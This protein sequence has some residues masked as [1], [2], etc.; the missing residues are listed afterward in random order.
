MRELARAAGYSLMLFAPALLMASVVLQMPWLTVA[1]LICGLP[2]LRPLFGDACAEVPEW[3]EKTATLLDR[4]PIVGAGAVFVAIA[5]FVARLPIL[6]HSA[7]D[8][9]WWGASLWAS[10]VFASC[11][12]HELVHR[13]DQLSRQVGRVLSGVIAYPLLE[14]EH[15]AHHGTSGNVLAA[16][17]PRA[18]ENVWQFSRR[19][20]KRVLRTAWEG[21]VVAAVRAGHR[22]AGGLPLALC[23]FGLTASAFALGGGLWGIVLY[24]GVT[25]AVVWSMQAVTYVQ[26]WGLGTDSVSN[27]DQGEFGW[28]DRCRLQAWLTLSIS[29][30]Q[31]HHRCSSVPYY[32]QTPIADAPRMPAGYVVLLVASV[33]PPLWRAWMIPVLERWKTSPGRQS[34]AGRRLFC[35]GG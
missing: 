16:E 26:H 10:F 18:D 11:I 27:A 31:A 3:S 24:A 9:A 15:R 23:S 5:L 20:L 34:G 14:H 6:R 28:E 7:V 4:L 19:R 22:L 35:I 12:A 29:Y 17:W 8:L 33:I 2:F 32:R 21:D 25:L 13:R 30:H 1:V